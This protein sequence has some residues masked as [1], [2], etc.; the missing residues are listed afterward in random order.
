MLKVNRCCL[1]GGLLAEPTPQSR[2]TKRLAAEIYLKMTCS[3]VIN[4][5]K[6]KSSN[7]F[8]NPR[9]FEFKN[10]LARHICLF[11]SSFSIMKTDTFKTRKKIQ[12][13]LTRRKMCIWSPPVFQKISWFKWFLVS[14]NVIPLV[15]FSMFD[16]PSLRGH[17]FKIS[18]LKTLP[19]TK[20]HQKTLIFSRATPAFFLQLEPQGF[21][22]EPKN[23][24]KGGYEF[25]SW[26]QNTFPKGR[27]GF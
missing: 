12:I 11:H 21:Y 27:F 24:P 23:Y 19:A 8:W 4:W 5:T 9:F 16:H 3:I 14:H 26:A 18:K 2:P 10:D 25:W 17:N 6:L 22:P 15:L 20:Q 7:V 1:N 13:T